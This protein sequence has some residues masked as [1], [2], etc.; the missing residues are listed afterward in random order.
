[1][2]K[3]TFSSFQ[4]LFNKA[5]DFIRYDITLVQNDLIICVNPVVCEVNYTNGLPVVRNL[6]TTA[7]NYTCNLVGNNEVQILGGKLI[8]HKKPV[9]DLDRPHDFVTHSWTRHGN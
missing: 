6:T 8:P 9:F 3:Q 7:I 2:D 1:M 5:E 4:G